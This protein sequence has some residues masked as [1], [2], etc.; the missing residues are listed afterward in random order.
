VEPLA[1]GIHACRRGG[2]GPGASAAVLGA[3]PIGLLAL[4]AA[5]A[6]GAYPVVCTDL[7]PFRLALAAQLG[8]RPVEAA[9]G[10]PVLAVRAATGGDGPD[11]VIETAGTADTIR[12]AMAMVKTGGVVVLVGLPPVDEMS[13]PVMD[14]LTREYDLR[15][16]FRYANCYPPALSLLAAGKINLAPLRTHAFGLDQAEEALRQAIEHKAETIKVLVK[17]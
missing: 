3:G 4:Q 5:A 9:A 2:V 7:M 8:A 10:D 15:T 17:P 1:V 14:Q 6:Y 11:V 13:L 16:V 12:Q